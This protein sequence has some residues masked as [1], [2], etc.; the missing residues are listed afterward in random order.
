MVV[1]LVTVTPYKARALNQS[2]IGVT[3]ACGVMEP[4][5]IVNFA[6]WVSTC[7]ILNPPAT[8]T[9]AVKTEVPAVFVLVIVTWT[10]VIALKTPGVRGSTAARLTPVALPRKRVIV[11]SE[12]VSVCMMPL[13]RINFTCNA[14][15][16]MATHAPCRVLRHKP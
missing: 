11:V 7:R 13:I 14:R 15:A 16:P 10:Y 9:R 4:Q 5:P 8:C 3:S 2:L 6:L 1:V 12:N